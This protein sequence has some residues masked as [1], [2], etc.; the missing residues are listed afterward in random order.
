MHIKIFFQILQ[1]LLATNSLDVTAGDLNY[2]LLKALQIK[3]LDILT[4]YFQ[5]VNKP[6]HICGY[7]MDHVYIKKSFHGREFFINATA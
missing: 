3:V 4:D 7:L 1:Y 6:T 5:M 2:D